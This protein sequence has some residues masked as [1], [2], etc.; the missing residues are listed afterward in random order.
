MSLS[1]TDRENLWIQAGGNPVVASIAAAISMAEDTSGDPNVVSPTNDVGLWQ[2]NLPS[3][4][5]Y[6][7]TE[8]Q[9]PLSNAKAAV[10]ISNNG[11]NWNPWTS[12]T[13]GAYLRFVSGSS[14]G[15][16]T[17]FSSS[18]PCHTS[19]IE[20]P[21]VGPLGGGSVCFDGWLGSGSMILGVL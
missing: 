18:S 12:Y 2:I 11:R 7:V 1:F 8:L 10:A 21:S 3:H 16:S 4:P 19:N 20:L 13:S 5:Q 9:D 14:T 17:L 15:V 6:N